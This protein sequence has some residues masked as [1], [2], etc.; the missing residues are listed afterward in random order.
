MQRR[1][2]LKALLVL[3]LTACG[4]SAKEEQVIQTFTENMQAHCI[5]RFL[6][7]LPK[8]FVQYPDAEVTLYYGRDKNFTTVEV[9]VIEQGAT[10]KLFVSMFKSELA[11][12][13]RI[14]TSRPRVRC[15][16]RRPKPTKWPCFGTIGQ[17]LP[18][19]LSLASYTRSWTTC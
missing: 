13:R 7:D 11:K 6:I 14:P 16:L 18:M 15:L 9:K 8:G 3:P 1:S 19:T 10:Q 2:P 12:F 5:G 4:R 17:K